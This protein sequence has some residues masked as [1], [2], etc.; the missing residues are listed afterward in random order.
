[1]DIVDRIVGLLGDAASEKR[2][3][4][5]IVIGELKLGGQK[6]APALEKLLASEVYNVQVAGLGAL[7][8]VGAKKS[9][10]LVFPLLMAPSDDVRR[11]A[12]RVIV[13][14]GEDAVG[15]I[16][17][18]LE[19]ALPEERRQ[20]DAILAELGGDDAF[21]ALLSA[22]DA[23]SE[24][25]GKN[26]ALAIRHEIKRANAQQRRRYV[27]A[28]EKFLRRKKPPLPVA[29]VAT[30]LKI[31]GYLEDERGLATLLEHTGATQPPSVRLEA[32]IALRFVA[33]AESKEAAEALLTAAESTE[34]GLAV[35]ALHGLMR[36]ALSGKQA[37]RLA[38]LCQ[39]GDREIAGLAMQQL[40]ARPQPEATD[41]LVEIVTGKNKTLAETAA[42]FLKDR[43]D[44]IAPLFE[45]LL[46]LTDH[47][48]AWLVRGAL[49]GR[50]KQLKP[51]QL[52]RARD[53][54]LDR[55]QKGE[56]GYE[57]AF[58][59]A[60]SGDPKTLAADLRE[61]AAKLHKAKKRERVHAVLRLLCRSEHATNDDLY[62]LAAL[63]LEGSR[64]DTSP[65]ARRADEAIRLL[66]LLGNKGFDFAGLLLKDRSLE[67]NHLYFA[68]FH[69]AERRSPAG[70][71][72]LEA[73]VER[74][75]RTKIGKM[76]KN[77]LALTGGAAD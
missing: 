72:L 44:A 5:A 66:E 30:G 62:R 27:A 57:A 76:A 42:D 7:A 38:K 71:E 59:V 75:G 21:S 19:I 6:V 10:K 16:R 48:R 12:S 55:I 8:R 11:A 64:L 22:L 33:P 70:P 31:L 36:V 20:L 15:A 29:A 23:P 37:K 53:V 40:G 50:A 77:K 32:I 13:S 1:M 14:V 61:L 54:A 17:E 43:S 39:H 18:R 2:I 35:A 56:R 45:A 47:D 3:A 49:K 73:V 24:E 51:A 68:G 25:A 67:P 41:A 74:A 58:D 26:A 9:L 69:F 4:A 65:A 52:K 34:R 60:E 46:T 28:T 63:E